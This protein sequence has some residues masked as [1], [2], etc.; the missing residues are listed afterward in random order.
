MKCLLSARIDDN[1]DQGFEEFYLKTL[2]T[3][4]PKKS[5]IF[6]DEIKDCQSDSP[7]T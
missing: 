7:E 2:F 3:K 6:R 1:Q 4:I 5:V